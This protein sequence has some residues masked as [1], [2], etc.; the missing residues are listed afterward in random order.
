MEMWLRRG[1]KNRRFLIRKKLIIACRQEA[2]V[3]DFLTNQDFIWFCMEQ[4]Q[5]TPND[6][7]RPVP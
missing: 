6:K 5:P 2:A 3:F 4:A 7:K 1:R